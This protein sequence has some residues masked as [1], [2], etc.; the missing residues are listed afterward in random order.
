[1]VAPFWHSIHHHLGSRPWKTFGALF[2]VRSAYL[3]AYTP[4]AN[5]QAEV[6]GK[7]FKTFLRKIAKEEHECWVQ[8]ISH[9]LRMYHDI[10]GPTGLSPYQIIF[11]RHRPLAGLPYEITKPACDAEAFFLQ[12]EKFD[13]LVADHMNALH[14]QKCEDYNKK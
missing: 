7:T 3:Q 1:M 2:G 6:A 5:G 10:P 8:L 4:P 9:V 11:G 12:M 14:Q 13:G